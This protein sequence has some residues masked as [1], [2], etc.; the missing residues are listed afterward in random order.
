M[1][2]TVSLGT[3]GPPA[4]LDLLSVSPCCDRGQEKNQKQQKIFLNVT[5]TSGNTKVGAPDLL[6]MGAPPHLLHERIPGC[7]RWCARAVPIGFISLFR[8]L[9][10]GLQPCP[11]CKVFFT[12]PYHVRAV[13][14]VEKSLA[15]KTPLETVTW[16][17]HLSDE[18]GVPPAA[19]MHHSREWLP[20]T[21]P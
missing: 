7:S 2:P 10:S 1:G 6:R 8:I 16:D 17:S 9:P 21:D 12:V 18:G 20:F 11:R 3:P 13:L 4:G 19:A 14:V 15:S 5:Y